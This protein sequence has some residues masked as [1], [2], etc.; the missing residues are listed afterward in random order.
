MPGTAID[1]R[2]RAGTAID[3]R[4]MAGM[5]IGVKTTTGTID[6]IVTGIPIDDTSSTTGII[7]LDT[8]GTRRNTADSTIHHVQNTAIRINITRNVISK[9]AVT[10][11][12]RNKELQVANRHRTP[13]LPQDLPRV[14][15]MLN[16]AIPGRPTA[17]IADRKATTVTNARR[18]ATINDQQ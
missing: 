11:G 15:T 12:I 13:R 18:K 1:E 8:V 9:K 5:V 6:L 10:Q 14:P 2:M 7:P 4:V 16:P 3:E 17:I